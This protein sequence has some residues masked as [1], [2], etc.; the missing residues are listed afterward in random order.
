M[1]I[2]LMLA[3]SLLAGE[4]V[5]L[6]KK[7][8]PVEMAT[9]TVTANT[10]SIEVPV[11]ALPS[12][13]GGPP[14]ESVL[15]NARLALKG[16]SL[17][18][19]FRKR[20]PPAPTR[21]AIN[22]LIAK[23][24]TGDAD[25][26]QEELVAMG[27]PALPALREAINGSEGVQTTK[28]AR[29]IIATLEGEASS[30]LIIQAARGLASTRPA[31]AVKAM[32]DYLPF[33]EDT[34]SY[35]ELQWAIQQVA[36]RDGKPDPVLLTALK[37]PVAVRRGTAALVLS[38]VGGPAYYSAIRPLL[39][40]P[41]P[42]VRLG[43]ALALVRALDSEAV[44]V[45][46]ELVSELPPSLRPTAEEY[47]VTLAGE[48]AVEGPKGFDLTSSKLRRAVWEA[49][50]KNTDGALLL[51]EFRSRTP[52]EEER[53]K[54]DALITKLADAKTQAEAQTELVT[55]GKKAVSQLRRTIN[56]GSASSEAAVKCL[57]LIERDEPNP[58]PQAA[59]RLLALR[60]P[61]GTVET[62]LGYLAVAESEDLTTQLTEVLA[63]VACPGGKADAVV[64]KALT[65][66]S[67]LRRV[68]A[69]Q[70]ITR[71]RATGAFEEVKKL[72]EDRDVL[73]RVR[74]ASAL[75]AAGEKAAILP[76][77]RTLKDVP[78][79]N[80]WE[81]EDLLTKVAADKAPSAP[82]GDAKDSRE[83]AV[84]AWEKW[85]KESEAG[86][87]LTKIDFTNNVGTGQLIVLEQYNPRKGGQGR[88]LEMDASGKVR[89]EMVL[90][91][92]HD[93]QVLRN[94]NILVVEQQNRVTERDRKGKILWDKYFN[95]NP[96]VLER[97]PNGQ[98]FLG[99]RNALIIVDKEG[100]QVFNYNY[101]T[102][103]ILGARRFRDG[104]MALIAYS[105]E[106]IRID[107]AGKELKRFTIP[108]IAMFGLSGAD[109][110]PGDRVIVS[111]QGN[112]KVAE[113]N[114]DGKEV[115]STTVQQPMPPTRLANG[116]TLVSSANLMNLFEIDRKG[117]IVK[118][119]KGL[120]VNPY[121][122]FRR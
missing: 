74:V 96:F 102:N 114:S 79:D 66:K 119:W 99:C 41:K 73:V 48:W 82:L 24:E 118:E 40:D 5:L 75:T 121:R 38:S 9:A 11:G 112:N 104:S 20:T 115:W 33:T 94:G 70:A 22:A 106:Y 54:I 31:G 101:T 117:K 86:L 113:Y 18:N 55:M 2:T 42:S 35:L 12:G 44:P 103:T 10:L 16:E 19:F 93:A 110:L 15:K 23:L 34:A 4:K 8:P 77:I 6:R 108:N 71:A 85:Y 80:A 58:M 111:V 45:L 17:L 90:N 109:I 3:T 107:K 30:Q 26:A 92:P 13:I 47:L 37:D 89:W 25:A 28:R 100:K 87:D 105:G 52:T 21:L 88:V 1:L 78:M 67:A 61:E 63:A 72:L 39:K 97:L 7:L 43:V 56:L 84:T 49:W 120:A 98:T 29:E 53:E 68:A 46:I 83:K 14:D 91:Y 36:M 69:A 76:L 27:L 59:A 95:N 51:A 64:L 122:A 81:V 60:K 50:W 116:N 62:L 57:E 32:L 65:D